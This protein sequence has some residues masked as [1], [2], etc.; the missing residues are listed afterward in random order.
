M[1]AFIDFLSTIASGLE[2]ICENI[3]GADIQLSVIL[4]SVSDSSSFSNWISQSDPLICGIWSSSVFPKS[5]IFSAS[6]KNCA[7]PLS[8]FDSV[9]GMDLSQKEL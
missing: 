6:I 7:F 8:I 1:T 3:S 5:N 2:M 9:V 4:V